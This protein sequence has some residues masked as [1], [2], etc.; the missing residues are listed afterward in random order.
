M[1]VSTAPVSPA[2]TAHGEPN[3]VA[4]VIAAVAVTFLL[5]LVGVGGGVWATS[6]EMVSGMAV[7]LFTAFWGGP[8]F[9]IMAGMALYNLRL[10]RLHGSH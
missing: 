5:F 4:Y 1:T 2:S 6:G 10:E 3:Q 7:G 9:G 8:G